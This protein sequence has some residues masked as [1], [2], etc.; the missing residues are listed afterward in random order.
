MW[1]KVVISMSSSE[2]WAVHHIHLAKIRPLFPHCT[3]RMRGRW[4]LIQ[5]YLKI[6]PPPLVCA[7][8]TIPHSHR[9]RQSMST[10]WQPLWKDRPSSLRNQ[11]NMLVLRRENNGPPPPF[12]GPWEKPCT[13]YIF[14]NKQNHTQRLILVFTRCKLPQTSCFQRH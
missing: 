6:G 9:R 13:F 4:A 1:T 3:S 11:R 10:L 5:F 12:R 8:Y 7:N 14:G 2:I